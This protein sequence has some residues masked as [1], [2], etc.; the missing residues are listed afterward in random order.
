MGNGCGSVGSV[1]TSNT[2]NPQFQSSEWH[3]FIMTIVFSIAPIVY[4]QLIWLL[5]YKGIKYRTLRG[6]LVFRI[7]V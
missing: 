5:S 3:N 7:D 1:V 2:R 6:I 4:P